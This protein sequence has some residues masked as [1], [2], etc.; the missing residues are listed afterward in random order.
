MTTPISTASNSFRRRLP[1][2]LGIMGVLSCILAIAALVGDFFLAPKE[3]AAK[4]LILIHSPSNGDQLEVGQT[5]TLHATASDE[6][7]ITRI[8][9]WLDGELS[10]VETSNLAGGISPFPILVNWQPTTPGTHILTIRAFNSRGIRAHAYI[11]IEAVELPDQDSDGV[12][13]EVDD[14]PDEASPTRDGCPL[15][16]DRDVDGVSDAEDACPDEPGWV[17]RD[18]CPTPGDSDG[19]G[20]ADGEDACPE[21]SGLP[22]VEGCPD[23]DGDSIPDHA[24]ADPDEPGPAESGGA[25]D[26]DGD[27]VPDDHDLAP[28]EPGPPEGGGAPESDA[29]DSDGDGAADDVDPCPDDFGE[30]EDGFCPAPEDDSS[31]GDDGPIFELPF[32]FFDELELY[33]SLE[34]E[35]YLFQVGEEY[36]RV[37]CYVQVADEEVRRYEF[38]P[39]GE[40]RW[41]IGEVLGAEN[42]IHLAVPLSEPLPVFVDCWAE[43]GITFW[44]EEGDDGSPGEGGGFS[45][46]Y[47]LGSFSIEHPSSEWDGRELLGVGETADGN[48]FATWYRICSP[49]C[50]ETSLPAPILAPITMGPIGDGPYTL[51][52]QWEGN[53]EL[54]EGFL[55]SIN[56]TFY[57][58]YSNIGTERR[59]LDIAEFKPSCGEVLE[60]N[61][62]AGR[63]FT[64]LFPMIHSPRSNTQI[65]DGGNCP[66]TV[67]VS[68]ATLDTSGFSLRR[69]PIQGTFV[70]NDTAL[71]ADFRSGP[72][73]FDAWDDT[74]RYLDPGEIYN[75]AT[76]FADIEREATS[77]IGSSCTRNYAPTT[78]YLEI[79]L[80]PRETLTFGG[81]LFADGSGRIFE[82]Y[83]SIAPDEIVPG[84]YTIS[85]GGIELTVYID[86]LVGPEAGGTDH[87]PDLTI[88][89]ITAEEDSGQLRF[90][91]FNNAAN[92]VDEDIEI[93]LVRL[94]TGEQIELLNWEGITIPSGGMRIL[95]T[96]RLSMEPFDLRAIIDPNNGIEETNDRNN[97]FETAASV[98]VEFTR[99][100]WGNSVC[101]S[102]LN[103]NGEFRF[104]MWVG[105]RSP[106]GD[107]TW[108]AER[109]HP[110]AGTVDVDWS[111]SWPDSDHPETWPPG[112]VIEGD[113]LYNIELE[114]PAGHTLVIKADGYEDDTGLSGDDYAGRVFAEFTPEM[115]YGSRPESYRYTSTDFHDCPDV[116]PLG[117]DDFNFYIW[118]RITRIH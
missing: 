12:A 36:D 3:V 62:Y 42:S 58:A 92:M 118:W 87:L 38:E 23:R 89:D 5:S 96:G 53:E 24:D 100:R 67:L 35:A 115:N 25:P 71:I 79:D 94:S 60:F 17:D 81:R 77:C 103:Q 32:F 49:A 66:R 104:R 85:D 30:A 95:Q 116:T 59:S 88:A 90:H 1:I 21:E 76:L 98:R 6:Q 50:D 97:I 54:I 86:V 31:P 110:W 19:D 4:P 107:I 80:G 7:N 117:W 109:R 68:F 99:F 39:E 114:I 26:S 33:V 29:P 40:N 69:G 65:W 28:E 72:P 78:N 22:E 106:D 45:T 101:E 112:W 56:G 55:M 46:V 102:F 10:H 20:V 52:W 14:C 8:E 105:H 82:A 93:N 27:T 37:W 44:T 47:D 111:D 18:G 113:S 57:D 73:S 41:N 75:I 91:V 64:G 61:M 74:K 83:E 43:D 34:L 13:D 16:D 70:A 9:F 63:E 84:P 48:F 11:N 108:V 2:I 51:R 15:P